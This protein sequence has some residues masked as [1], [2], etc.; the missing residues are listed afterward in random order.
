MKIFSDNLFSTNLKT[1]NPSGIYY[2]ITRY[3]RY[4]KNNVKNYMKIFKLIQNHVLNC[5]NK[6]CPGNR[7]LPKSLSYSIFTDFKHY[8]NASNNSKSS[9]PNPNVNFSKIKVENN[10]IKNKETIRKSILK[11][12]KSK[13][14]IV[15]KNE[16]VCRKSVNIE[17]N[18]IEEEESINNNN[19]K[20]LEDAEF[21]MIGEQEIINRINYLYRRKKFDYMQTYIFLHLQY[22]IKIK[23]NYRLALY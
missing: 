1:I 16:S 11:S 4:S 18:N 17:L 2:Y 10:D 21:K 14:N 22:I 20:M 19:K 7:L 15:P 8:S 3:I 13:K 9:T 12:Q 5:Q 6:N 23:Q